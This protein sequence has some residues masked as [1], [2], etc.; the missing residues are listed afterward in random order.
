M[1]DDT[2]ITVTASCERC[3]WVA[4]HDVDLASES[5]GEIETKMAEELRQHVR[6]SHMSSKLPGTSPSSSEYWRGADSG[7]FG[8]SY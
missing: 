5:V 2:E 7:L 3:S 8:G 6:T 1:D 4:S